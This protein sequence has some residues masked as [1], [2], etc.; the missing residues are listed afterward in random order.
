MCCLGFSEH[1]RGQQRL[2]EARLAEVVRGEDPWEPAKKIFVAK[3]ELG[4]VDGYE[5][6][7]GPQ[8]WDKFPKNLD[9]E[10]KSLICGKK[11]R[12]LAERV[13]YAGEHLDL[14]CRELVEGADIGC[15]G[16]ARAASRSTNAESALVAGAQ[17]TDA[18]A[19]WVKSGFV[20]GPVGEEEVPP[21]AKVNGIMCRPKPNG[22]VRII[23]NMSAPVGRS[24]NDG[25]DATE[26]PASMSS[27]GKWLAV[28]DKAGRGCKIMKM[29]WSDAYKHV[30][31]R[32]QDVDLQW[33]MWLGL[34]F[35]ELCLIF[36]TS[37]SV[38]IYDRVAKVVLAIALLVARFPEDLVCQHLDD[39]CAAG[40]AD[41]GALE[42]FEKAYKG[43]AA[44]V[45][46]RLAPTT[47]PDKAFSPCHRGTVL[48]VTYDTVSWTWCI[49]PDKVARLVVQIRAALS[50]DKVPQGEIWSLVGRIMHYCPLI[51]GGRFNL[52]YL[53]K[54]NS[55]SVDRRHM[56]ELGAD[57]RRQLWFWLTMVKVSS[58]YARIPDPED[59][60]PVWTRE[61]Y[62]DAA[63]GSLSGVGRGSGAVSMGWWA[64][65]PWARKINC[66]VRA[67]DGKKLS[68]KLSALELVGPLVCVAAGHRWCRGR[69]VRIWVD[70]IG[71]VRIWKKGY[72]SSCGLSTT[73][74]KAIA[75]VA[76]GIGCRVTIEKITRCSG[77][78]AVM[79]DALSK[80]EFARFREVAAVARWDLDVGP[81]VVP[82]SLLYW[83]ADPVVDDQ[84]GARLL[85]E[86]SGSA[87]VLGYSC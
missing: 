86:M 65:V 39:V 59:K 61:C 74:V 26:F 77:T 2:W 42:G 87:A 56:V 50:A 24:V 69:P 54:A 29:D 34:F 43:V 1:V 68:R 81:A 38:G 60:F 8:F 75:T 78:G 6:L 52:D 64:Q 83:L 20:Y 67:E 70:N 63:G 32:K 28:L 35:V 85:R 46:V 30:H 17:V 57:V 51:P 47:D 18:I 80:G 23:L 76:A 33:F 41:T 82:G 44:Q 48:G 10:G 49:P 71:S 73:L 21:E 36:G 22:S 16:E 7:A 9:K 55:V 13:G 40:P 25:I 79:A 4:S 14:V 15:R 19:S 5:G 12:D 45:G 62:T 11:L 66:G 53:V 37:S 27:T 3:N 72:S 31:V 58:G 84:L